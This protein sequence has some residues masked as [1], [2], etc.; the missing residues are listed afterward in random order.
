MKFSWNSQ[1]SLECGT[2]VCAKSP[3]AGYGSILDDPDVQVVAQSRDSFLSGLKLYESRPHK[4]YSL[5]DCISMH[6]MRQAGI[7]DVLTHDR[8]FSQEGYRAVFR[9]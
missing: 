4:L 7:S 2:D 3:R 6:T 9:E 8:H 1:L 5:T